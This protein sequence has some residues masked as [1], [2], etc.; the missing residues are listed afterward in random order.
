MRLGMSIASHKNEWNGSIVSLERNVSIW[1]DANAHNLT[2]PLPYGLHP[3]EEEFTH[4]EGS[5]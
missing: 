4:G 2:K 1:G 5:I 3:G